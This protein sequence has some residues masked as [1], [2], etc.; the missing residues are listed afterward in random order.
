MTRF[1]Q[2]QLLRFDR[3]KLVVPRHPVLA[4]WLGVLCPRLAWVNYRE[5]RFFLAIG[6]KPYH[7]SLRLT[8]RE[9][10]IRPGSWV[11]EAYLATGS[12]DEV[13]DSRAR[14][15]GTLAIC[16]GM[17]WSEESS[18]TGSGA[19]GGSVSKSHQV[20]V[21]IAVLSPDQRGQHQQDD[22]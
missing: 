7:L 14:G 12:K 17:K 9:Q 13:R 19:G 5:A 2:T 8:W 16:G 1:S 21:S 22:R 6:L 20:S 3:W 18:S 11:S 15:R 10:V 4:V